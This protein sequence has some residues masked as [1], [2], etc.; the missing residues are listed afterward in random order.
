MGPVTPMPFPC[1]PSRDPLPPDQSNREK[2]W[3]VPWGWVS[4]GLLC[5]LLSFLRLRR[6]IELQDFLASLPRR[7]L[8]LL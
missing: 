5:D 2:H 6:R 4:V 8:P 3:Q 1:S 7:A